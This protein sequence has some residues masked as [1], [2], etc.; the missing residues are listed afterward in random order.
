MGADPADLAVVR[1]DGGACRW[2]RLG[3]PIRQVIGPLRNLW[4]ITV[5][6]D[7]QQHQP[8]RQQAGITDKRLDLI[9]TDA[10]INQEFR[11]SSC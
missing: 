7:R 6:G 10:A 2:P 8:Q 9:Q 3:I 1:V 4:T 5:T 11:R